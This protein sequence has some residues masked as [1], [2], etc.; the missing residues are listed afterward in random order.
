MASS[1]PKHKSA[2]EVT[3]VTEEKS[4]LAQMVDRHWRTAA[5][6]ALALSAW[7]LY[8]E[9][10]EDQAKQSQGDQWD[11]LGDAAVT[12]EPQEL[13]KAAQTSLADT[14]LEGW[15]ALSAVAPLV[16]E[17]DYSAALEAVASVQSAATPLLTQL[18][19]PIGANGAEVA[20]TD[21]LK[22]AIASQSGQDEALGGIF[23]N[24]APPEGA[25]VVELDISIGGQNHTVA[26]ALYA[27]EAPKHVENFIELVESNYY[28]GTKFHRIIKDFMVQGGD[29]NTK[30]P[31]KG[32]ETWGQGGPEYKI[33][34]EAGD[35]VHCQ[36]VVAAAKGN[37]PQSSGSQFY[38]TTG[39][40][41]HLDGVHTVFGSVIEG[42]S[43]IDL[44]NSS[45]I[46]PNEAATRDI[47][48]DPIP[49]IVAARIR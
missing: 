24:P 16:Q 36:Y 28:E 43:A 23:E 4:A 31:A 10:Q 37:E 45:A 12:G 48:E 13:M 26:I 30:D 15:A 46:R 2:T 29:P 3:I 25:P 21:R 1:N 40:P 7:V 18:P 32:M 39:S 19:L 14:G 33:E 49:T 6:L 27:D 42:R 47:P 5:L 11:V 17:R 8:S 35:L 41:H 34:S 44:L 38:I 22:A 20:I 9:H